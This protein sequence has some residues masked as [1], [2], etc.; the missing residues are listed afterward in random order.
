VAQDWIEI[1]ATGPGE[2]KD[3]ASSLLI[4]SGSPGVQEET[5]DSVAGKLVS[6]SLWEEETQEDEDT[7]PI[8]VLKA[9]LPAGDEAALGAVKINLSRI[10]WTLETSFLK[11]TDWSEKWK[12]GLKPIKVK[13]RGFSV[14]VKPTWHKLKRSP[15]EIMINI[16]PGMA[17]GTGGHATTKMCLKSI[18]RLVKGSRLPKAPSILDVGTGT[19]VLAIAAVKLGFKKAIG[20][21]IDTVALKVARKNASLN[22]TKFS[23]SAKDLSIV[24]GKFD[25]VAA[26]ILAGE[27]TRL[28]RALNDKI[29]P[30]GFLILSGILDTEK[31][32][33]EA[34]FSAIGL[35][36]AFS[37]AEKEWVALVFGKPAR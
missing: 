3:L 17:F 13:Y 24:P 35:K 14:I 26:N 32:A 4:A 28:S 12:K 7:S 27:L 29:K 5:V 34:T 20:T 1:R 15:G 2:S 9:Y 30:G 19:G 36:K 22:K 25:L 8:R 11:D 18:L 6:H 10:G 21:D 33:I 23:L 37:L 31:T 16:D